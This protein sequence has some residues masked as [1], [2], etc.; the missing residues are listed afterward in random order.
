MTQHTITYARILTYSGTLPL[1]AS[2]MLLLLPVTGLD[3]GYIA[4]TYSAIILSFLSGIHWAVY[5]FFAEKCP[6]NLLLTS[7]AI[8]LLAWSVL[9]GVLSWL[10]VLL[11]ILCFL[12]LLMLDSKLYAANLY[13]D[14]FYRLRRNATIMVVVCLSIIM[15]LV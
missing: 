8:T 4:V 11:H 10:A 15:G 5:L 6:R 13:P 9:L 2:V 3:G 12:Y 7:N 1:I 14:W